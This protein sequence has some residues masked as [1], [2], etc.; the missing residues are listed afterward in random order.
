MIYAIAT[1][2]SKLA[3]RFSK[4]EI[5]TLYNDQNDIIASLPNPALTTIGCRGKQ[6]IIKKLREF[7]CHTIIV[8]KIGQ[9]SLARLLNAGFSIEQGSTRDS[10]IELLDNARKHKRPLTNADQGVKSQGD[11]CSNKTACRTL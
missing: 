9:K 5:F 2:Q 10:T 4:S 1:N 7:N 8:R 11:C 6:L 3:H